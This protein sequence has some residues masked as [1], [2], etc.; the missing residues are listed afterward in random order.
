MEALYDDTSEA[1]FMSDGE[2]WTWG[3]CYDEDE[4]EQSQEE[5]FEVMLS[6]RRHELN[7]LR[8]RRIREQKGKYIIIANKGSKKLYLQDQKISSGGYWTQ[9]RS[10]ARTFNTAEEANKVLGYFHLGNPRAVLV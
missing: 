8:S 10:N 2:D 9:F 6:R 4:E 3:D 7:K 1:D 5:D